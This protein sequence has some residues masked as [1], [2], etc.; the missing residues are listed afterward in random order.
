VRRL[1]NGQFQ[2]VDPYAYIP[3]TQF[4]KDPY[5]IHSD[6]LWIHPYP[7]I[8]FLFPPSTGTIPEPSAGIGGEALPAGVLAYPELCSPPDAVPSGGKL[9]FS[10]SLSPPPAEGL[11]SIANAIT[12]AVQDPLGNA[13]AQLDQPIQVTLPYAD[14]DLKN[15]LPR[16]LEIRRL[17]ERE[18]DWEYIATQFDYKNQIAGAHVTQPGQYALFGQ[19]TEDRIPPQT[20]ITAQGL[21]DPGGDWCE[22]VK[23]TITS[24][25]DQSPIV[26]LQYR[27][28]NESSWVSVDESSYIT[29]LQ[30]PAGKPAAITGSE[31]NAE[32]PYPTG[33]G[34]YLVQAMAKDSQGNM[35]INPAFLYIVIDPTISR[36]KCEATTLSS[37]DN[38]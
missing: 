15:I 11:V 5:S 1:I 29:T 3:S 6:Y 7:R 19:P 10:L 9:F 27:L 32:N 4:P 35:E 24:Q 21:K 22:A 18:N 37:A 38:H 14:A 36:S 13:F 2:P 23:V 28:S 25:D 8:Q 33:D 31:D 26:A 20:V 17:N 34:R 12:F 30:P 16:S